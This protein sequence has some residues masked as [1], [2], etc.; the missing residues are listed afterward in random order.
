MLTDYKVKSPTYPNSMYVLGKSVPVIDEGS[1]FRI[2]GTHTIDKFKI[3]SVEERANRVFLYMK[4][5]TVIL[6]VERMDR[7][8]EG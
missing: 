5:K 2:D 1:F 6:E 3:Q 8:V 4:D 7:N